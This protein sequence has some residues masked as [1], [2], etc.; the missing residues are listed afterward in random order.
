M[1]FRKKKQKQVDYNN[2]PKHIA[3]ICDGNRRWARNR[4]LPTLLGHKEG[5]EAIKRIVRRASEIGME[6]LTFF[7]FSTENFDRSKEEV[8]YL[9]N[10]FRELLTLKENFLQHDYRFHH[11]GDRS[12]LPKDILDVIDSMT[13]ETAHCKKGTVNLAFAYGGR[14]DIVNATKRIIKEKVKP[15]DI[16]EESFKNYL[17]TGEMPDVDLLVRTSGEKRISG[18]LLY[19][20]PYA[21]LYFVEKHWPSFKET[22][23]DDCI[24]E[25]QSRHRRFGK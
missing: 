1:F 22:D 18:F 20:M 19:N 12:M 2:L 23:L 24:G 21:E 3:F 15:E 4:G 11:T 14:N 5:V 6:N 10:L 16:T 7:C 17:T 25:F 9:F 8:D 13:K